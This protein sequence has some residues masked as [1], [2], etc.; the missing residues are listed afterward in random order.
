MEESCV[1]QNVGSPALSI[2]EGQDLLANILNILSSRVTAYCWKLIGDDPD[3][4]H[5]LLDITRSEM[6]RILCICGIFGEDKRLKFRIFEDF[7]AKFKHG[8]VMWQMYRPMNTT[9]RTPFIRIG[10]LAE[11]VEGEEDYSLKGSDQYNSKGELHLYPR[12]HRH[13]ISIKPREARAHLSVLMAAVKQWNKQQESTNDDTVNNCIPSTP[14]RS[15]GDN[16]ATPTDRLLKFV[17][18]QMKSA[19]QGCSKG[20]P[21]SVT[22]RA[23]RQVRKSLTSL[24]NE[25]AVSMLQDAI[26]RM[27]RPDKSP[28]QVCAAHPSSSSNTESGVC[29]VITP[30]RRSLTTAINLSSDEEDAVDPVGNALL[31]ELNEESVLISLLGKRMG[32]VGESSNNC[33]RVFP[34]HTNNGKTLL[35]VLPPDT[36]TKASFIDKAKRTRWIDDMLEDGDSDNKRQGILSYFAR[37]NPTG[38]KATAEEE[39]LQLTPTALETH[40][41]VAMARL[42]NLN[43]QQ[44]QLMRSYLRRMGQVELKYS[45]KDL[46]A[47]DN[48]VGLDFIASPVFGSFTYEWASSANK[49]KKK[50]PPEKCLFWNTS[51]LEQLTAEV[52]LHFH[53]LFV[54]DNKLNSFPALDYSSGAGGD[55]VVILFGGDHGDTSCP[56]SVKINFSSPAT[57]KARN[58]IGYQCVMV[59]IASV[60]CTKDTYEILENTVMPRVRQ[61]INV[62]NASSVLTV[63]KR[64]AKKDCFK[65][66][67][68]HRTIKLVTVVIT[69]QNLKPILTYVFEDSHGQARQASIDLSLRFKPP[70]A[71]WH[72][73]QATVTVSKFV[74]YYV[75]DLAF[76]AML[77]GMTNSERNYCLLCDTTA[78]NF[79]CNCN[80]ASKRTLQNLAEYRQQFNQNHAACTTKTKPA[81]YH[82]VNSPLL[83]PC[84]PERIVVPILHCPMGLVDKILETFKA[85]ANLAEKL[86]PD[87]ELLCNDYKEATAMHKTLQDQLETAET[88]HQQMATQASQAALQATQKMI[89]ESKA[90]VRSTKALF[91]EAM[92]LHNARL[93][94]FNQNCEDIYRRNG[95]TREHYHGGKFN[96]VNCIR[97]MDKCELLFVGDADSGIAGFAQKLIAVKSDDQTEASILAKC[98]DYA[99]LLGLLDVI[100]S[101]VRG[102]RGLLPTDEDVNALDHALS[103]AKALWLELGLT[104]L[105]PK[106]HLTFDGH[107]LYQFKAFGG[108]ADK[109]D[110]SIEF[111][112]QILKRLRDRYRRVSSFQTRSTCVI[113]E[114]RRQ[115]SRKIQADIVKFESAK[116]QRA[117]TKRAADASQ[118]QLEVLEA[119]RAKRE[120]FVS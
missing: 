73:L 26:G 62:L 1:A 18:G 100:W 46:I 108:I 52:D 19:A 23:E 82:G 91:L 88:L 36:K 110:D 54:S 55:G 65:S 119:K 85:W 74:D 67:I 24:V 112:H 50:T 17:I 111:Q 80:E 99:K 101:S 44:L 102:V 3:S 45:K 98:T 48:E 34:L 84:N 21:F 33:K 13:K 105:Q 103:T 83:L 9:S 60:D 51:L 63:Y 77:L 104:T 5:K 56:V 76:L 61:D 90:R 40:E 79:N 118:R 31:K 72:E 16:A 64:T 115:R 53:H 57:R 28:T 20:S 42:L 2:A 69:H 114:L 109:A 27:S 35:V 116:K 14:G 113:R 95:V 38:Y 106:W 29:A 6:D 92:K 93:T 117:D 94:S 8:S 70:E 43:D 10:C 87:D 39:R 86:Q 4:L 89:L 15:V 107:L 58:D 71:A 25:A 75:G 78:A 37:Q 59:P 7:A 68:V 97:I 49:S 12:V 120:R 22:T 32:G 41:T 30:A 47:I 96:G 11:I 81:N 66:Y